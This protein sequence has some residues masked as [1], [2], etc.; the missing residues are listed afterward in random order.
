MKT[1]HWNHSTIAGKLKKVCKHRKFT[2]CHTVTMEC[3]HC[4]LDMQDVKLKN[5]QC[6]QIWESFGYKNLEGFAKDFI[7]GKI[8]FYKGSF[9]RSKL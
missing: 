9:V 3:K 1:D 4:P 5:Y 2:S 8:C 6:Y 7:N